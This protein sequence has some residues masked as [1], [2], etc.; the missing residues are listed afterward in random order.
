M[1]WA[2]EFDACESCGTTARPHRA[3]GLCRRC[4]GAQP[5]VAARH[6]ELQRHRRAT[7]GYP[8]ERAKY[9][10]DTEF[11]RTYRL[12]MWVAGLNRRARLAGCAGV[13][14]LEQ[15]LERIDF[16][17]GR[18]YLCGDE[19]E[20]MDHVKPLSAGGANIA[21]NLRPACGSCNSSKHNKWEGVAAL[22]AA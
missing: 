19:W 17:G 1:I 14:T 15:L 11:R 12:K 8:Q 18:C 2:S 4:Y 5:D 21:A 7:H 6:H 9:A 10:T 22:S 13:V 20:H 16:Y 3:K